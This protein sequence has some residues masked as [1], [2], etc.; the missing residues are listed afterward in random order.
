MFFRAVFCTEQ[1]RMISR[2]DLDMFSEFYFLP[3]LGFCKGYSLCMMAH[4]ENG[5]TSGIFR[6]FSR[7]FLNRT[8]LNDL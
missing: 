1:L 7:G 2:M 3:K 6:V 4:F 8:T 5:L